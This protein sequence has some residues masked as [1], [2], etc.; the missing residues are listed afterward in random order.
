MPDAAEAGNSVDE[1]MASAGR[2]TGQRR[3]CLS[4]GM[5]AAATFKVKEKPWRDGQPLGPS[6][7]HLHLKAAALLP[8]SSLGTVLAGSVG[9]WGGHI[10]C[11]RGHIFL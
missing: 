11:D 2:A 9:Q 1:S 4:P 7:T 3:S 6:F 10:A 8:P 5:S